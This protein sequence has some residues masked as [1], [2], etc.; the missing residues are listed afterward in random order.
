ML[1]NNKSIY[2]ILTNK[3]FINQFWYT[4]L[5]FL[6]INE[7][8]VFQILQITSQIYI[9]DIQIKKKYIANITN[10]NKTNIAEKYITKIKLITKIDFYLFF[11][12]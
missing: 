8:S 12:R 9:N 6:C 1:S 5:I 4:K 11:F 3:L 2:D 10:K 7:K